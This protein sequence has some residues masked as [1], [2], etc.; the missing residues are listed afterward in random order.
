MSDLLAACFKP[1]QRG[2]SKYGQGL[3]TDGPT[4]HF[5]LYPLASF[6]LCR[7]SDSKLFGARPCP[8]LGSLQRCAHWMVL[9]SSSSSYSQ[10]PQG[11]LLGTTAQGQIPLHWVEPLEYI[12]Q[13]LCR[14][15]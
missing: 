12:T 7:V 13:H 8:T 14:P 3:I 15:G 11:L 5:P 10:A 4:A 9:S 6:S 2:L 1:L